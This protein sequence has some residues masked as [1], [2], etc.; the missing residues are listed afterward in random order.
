MKFDPIKKDVYTDDGEFIKQLNCPYKIRWD[1]LETSNKIFRRCMNCD[2]LIVDT[3]LLTDVEILSL[4]RKN[5]NS[6][7]KISINQDNIKLIN[8]GFYGEK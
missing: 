8:N 2:Q 4:M 7:L 6:C 5:P 1:N 3:A